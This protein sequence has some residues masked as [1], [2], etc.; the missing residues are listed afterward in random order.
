MGVED[1]VALFFADSILPEAR[2]KGWQMA[3]I[4]ERLAAAQKEGCDLAMVTVLP[5]SLSHRIYERAGFELIYLRVNLQR[6]LG[7]G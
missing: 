5:G 4:R 2:R 7:L 6:E 3:L 1:G